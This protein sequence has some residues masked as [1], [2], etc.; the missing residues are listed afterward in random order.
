MTSVRDFRLRVLFAWLALAAL[1]GAAPGAE[2]AHV[3]RPGDTLW[4]IAGGH[5]GQ[6][7]RWPELQQR[8][9]VAEPRH[10]RPGTVLYLAD[11]RLLR[12]DEAMVL[13]VAG[14]ASL[15]R[16]GSA[17]RSVVRGDAV[18]A[19]D[20][21]TTAPDGFVTL[22]LQDGGRS[23]IPPASEI[24]IEQV[25]PGGVRFRLLQGSIES[26][27]RK[28]RE[29]ESFEIR[30]RSV[31][32]G[33]RG[34][35]FR[36]SDRP[37]GVTGEV[38]EGQ[39]AVRKDAAGAAPLLLQAHQ[40]VFIADGAAPEARPLL[41]APHFSDATSSGALPKIAEVDAVAGAQGYRWRVAQDEHFLVP[42]AEFSSVA[43]TLTLPN[44]LEGGFYHLRVAAL[45]GAQLEG[46]PAARPVYLPE[47]Q[48]GVRM[49]SDGR[50]EIRWA[51]S[52][53]RHYRLEL[54]RDPDFATRV[55]DLPDLQ[56]TGVVVGPFA[57]GGR[58]YWRVSETVEEARYG[59]PF[60]GGS[61]DAT[62][63]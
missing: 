19:G 14:A 29:G 50:V 44:G 49:M 57:V 20:V 21:L 36:V 43:P 40:G 47:P 48:G 51:A 53:A 26:Q 15:R 5:Y 63:R 27:V 38:T 2:E 22:G 18:R 33:V 1:P 10:L 17:D 6:P 31:V 8:N 13:A 30:A 62:S 52:S 9:G 28:Q 37:G 34:T 12:A 11:G 45:D 25:N 39:V 3:V 46:M 4:G 61:F 58:Y 32:L 23:V 24:E 54:A 59:R 60:A 7:V 42:V 55:S 35:R 56:A 41:P 16:A